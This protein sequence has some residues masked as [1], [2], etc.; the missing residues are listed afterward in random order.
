[1]FGLISFFPFLQ[2]FYVKKS[3]FD[4]FSFPTVSLFL[5][6]ICLQFDAILILKDVHTAE[7]CFVN[8]CQCK[9]K[10]WD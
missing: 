5:D 7:I 2:F 4:F 3:S 9:M 8:L 6:F 1:M 10:I